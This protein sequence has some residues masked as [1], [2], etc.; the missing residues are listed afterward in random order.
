MSAWALFAAI[1]GARLA[2][3]LIVWLVTPAPPPPV[4]PP[5]AC[6]RPLPPTRSKLEGDKGA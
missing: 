4:A 2:G 1:L 3:D 6:V 5:R